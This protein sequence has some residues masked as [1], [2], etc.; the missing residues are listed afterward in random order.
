MLGPTA[1]TKPPE[2]PL[3]PP[4]APSASLRYFFRPFSNPNPRISGLQIQFLTETRIH[5]KSHA[6]LTKQ[7]TEANPNRNKNAIPEKRVLPRNAQDFRGISER[8]TAAA[9]QLL[10]PPIVEPHVPDGE[11]KP[12]V[13]TRINVTK[14]GI[15]VME[16]DKLNRN[17]LPRLGEDVHPRSPLRSEIHLRSIPRRQALRAEQNP[18]S[19]LPIRRNAPPTLEIPPQD[20]G[21]NVGAVNGAIRRRQN[22]IN[23]PELA[24]KFKVPAQR[25]GAMVIGQD[26]AQAHSSKEKI[27]IRV[28]PVAQPAAEEAANF[29]G[30]V[31]NHFRRDVIEILAGSR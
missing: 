6:S 21:E 8:Q 3:S 2:S 4:L 14:V 28:V 30:P 10:P 5:L 31:V 20:D 27:S 26:A 15:R 19:K 25:S 9:K 7:S 11:K 12:R 22:F 29:P 24:K 13:V 17:R 18:P 1:K 16:L 23:R